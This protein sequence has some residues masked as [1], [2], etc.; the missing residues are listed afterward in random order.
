MIK[1]IKYQEN[2]A[3]AI[4]ICTLLKKH[5]IPEVPKNADTWKSC[6]K[7][8]YSTYDS[9]IEV[10]LDMIERIL[11][12][13]KD[14][15]YKLEIDTYRPYLS[16]YSYDKDSD[17]K[18]EKK[19]EKSDNEKQ[20]DRAK[21]FINKIAKEHFQLRF[22][23]IKQMCKTK[24]LKDYEKICLNALIDES[25]CYCGLSANNNSTK[26]YRDLEVFETDWSFNHEGFENHRKAYPAGNA[27]AVVYVYLKDRDDITCIECCYGNCKSKNKIFS[28]SPHLKRIYKFLVAIGYPISEEEQQILDG[29]HPIYDIKKGAEFLEN[30]KKGN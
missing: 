19:P 22:E 23:F 30:L 10:D 16:L 14:F 7:R 4:E 2:K 26:T 6:W 20:Y 11:K 12:A 3:K 25:K 28:E 17:T 15:Y 24:Q 29:T 8:E 9:L 13:K 27:I 21:R 18:S 5:N 1:I